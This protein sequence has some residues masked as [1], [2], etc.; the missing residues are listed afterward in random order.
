MH[1]L[2]ALVDPFVD[3]V[4]DRMHA[5]GDDYDVLHANYWVSGAVGHRLKHALDRPLVATFHTLAR[6]KAEAG[7]DD[8]PEQRARLEHEVIDCAD[9]M[10]ASTAEERDQLA[11]LYGAE[12]ARI[13]IVPPGVDHSVFRPDA[14][15]GAVLRARLGLDDRPVAPVRRAH[16]AAEGRRCR[17]PGTG[18][19]RRRAQHVAR[20]R[21]AERPVGRRRIGAAGA[22]GRRARARRS[23]PVPA[24]RSRHDRLADFYRAADVCV[25][26]SR[27]ESFGLVALEAAACGTPVVAAAVGGLRSLV[28]DGVTGFLVDGHDPADVRSAGRGGARESVA[29][30]GDGRG[31]GRAFGPL[32]VEHHRRAAAPFLRRSRRAQ[33]RAVPLRSEGQAQSAGAPDPERLAAA[34]A[35]LAAAP[36][37]RRSR[38][39]R[40]CRPSNTTRSIPRWYVRF[41]C[42]GR[43]AATIYFDLHQRTLRYELYFVPDP[44]GNHEDLYRFLLQRNHTLYGARFSIG[45][46]GDVYLTGRTLLEHLDVAELDRIIGVLYE[47]VEQWF[48]PVLRIASVGAEVVCSRREMSLSGLHRARSFA[49]VRPGPRCNGHRRSGKYGGAS[50]VPRAPVLYGR[51]R[52]A[53]RS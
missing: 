18:R 19:R 36:R 7:F 11:E 20:G 49:T 6:V 4:L 28:D 41:G 10:L 14:R 3:A 34:H 25:V 24:A 30:R 48:Q 52:S 32:L 15:N 39:S 31:R 37:G 44:P 51:T 45:P 26:P 40:G 43:D 5:T 53:R 50:E 38:T 12:P 42:D 33:P 23:R 17:P 21:R 27:S 16:P 29:R 46:D 35:L 22:A 9:L 2:T 47:L 8:E 13:E 1:D